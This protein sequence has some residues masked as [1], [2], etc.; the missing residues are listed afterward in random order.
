VSRLE[1][2]EEDDDCPLLWPVGLAALRLLHEMAPQRREA[3]RFMQRLLD[4]WADP[5]SAPEQWFWSVEAF[6]DSRLYRDE[7]MRARF[8]EAAE[9]LEKAG[10]N[11]S[12]LGRHPDYVAN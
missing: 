6:A 8:F 5:Q 12:R 1:D 7:S 4:A 2:F 9:Q 3:G 10:I 11:P